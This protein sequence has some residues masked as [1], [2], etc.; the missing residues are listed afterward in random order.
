M[1]YT[2]TAYTAQQDGVTL[3]YQ[4]TLKTAI[5]KAQDYAVQAF[6][7]WGYRGYGPTIVLRD[8]SGAEVHRE[9]L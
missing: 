7:A 9:R 8:E 5:R 6:P 2:Y 4:G 1:I 3:N